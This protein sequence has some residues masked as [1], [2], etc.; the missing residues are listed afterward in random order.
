[1]SEII[2]Y[3]IDRKAETER[4]N[5]INKD[6][7]RSLKRGIMLFAISVPV[8]LGSMGLMALGY[9]EFVIFALL[10]F[11]IFGLYFKFYVANKIN[12]QNLAALEDEMKAEMIIDKLIKNLPYDF[13]YVRDITVVKGKEKYHTDCVIFSR[14][15]AFT[16]T[17]V[18]GMGTMRSGVDDPEWVMSAKGLKGFSEDYA[19]ENPCP[20]IS[21][22][23]F[24]LQEHF[25][26]NYI[27]IDV[28]PILYL[29]GC[30]MRDNAGV[31]K[32]GIFIAENSG[33][34]DADITG[35]I[36]SFRSQYSYN[37]QNLAEFIRP[38]EVALKR[39]RV[40]KNNKTE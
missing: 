4:I 7:K 29:T 10:P 36:D 28:Y 18:N 40:K 11:V 26:E 1:M 2:R 8:A 38:R 25:K 20:Y 12:T 13:S 22:T 24:A 14:G 21:E 19:I 39:K 3:V 33:F 34:A 37:T 15:G 31:Q 23:A 16:L 9:W 6:K 32:N 5:R 35:Y 30:T 27:D 17:V